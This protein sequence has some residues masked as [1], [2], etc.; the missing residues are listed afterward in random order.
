MVVL[1]HP[2]L[3]SWSASGSLP[4]GEN[5]ATNHIWSC[6]TGGQKMEMEAGQG[7]ESA[8]WVKVALPGR[9]VAPSLSGGGRSEPWSLCVRVRNPHCGKK[10]DCLL[11]DDAASGH[12]YLGRNLSTNGAGTRHTGRC[13]PLV[14]FLKAK[15]IF[16]TKRHGYQNMNTGSPQAG[17]WPR[18]E[19]DPVTTSN[20]LWF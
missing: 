9:R 12:R 13:L 16:T 3:D 20:L 14:P 1:E 5:H 6:R 4:L 7:L 11:A 2:T 15:C 8:N 19:H 17:A 10:Q 18:M